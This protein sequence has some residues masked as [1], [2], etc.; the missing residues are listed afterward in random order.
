MTIKNVCRGERRVDSDKSSLPIL[1]LHRAAP[2]RLH[3][4]PRLAAP[5]WWDTEYASSAQCQE[6]GTNLL[7]Y[8]KVMLSGLRVA[9]AAA[10]LPE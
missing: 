4:A 3:T 2:K 9:A 8:M 6:L 5:I 10:Y 1:D 7:V